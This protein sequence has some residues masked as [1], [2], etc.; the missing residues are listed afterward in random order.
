MD[1]SHQEPR[2]RATGKG[3]LG[4]SLGKASVDVQAE[5]DPRA[6]SASLCCELLLLRLLRL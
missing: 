2:R 3:S 1:R 6:L 5:A 4:L